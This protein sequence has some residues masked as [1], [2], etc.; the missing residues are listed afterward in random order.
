M[1]TTLTDQDKTAVVAFDSY[2]EAEK[3]VDYLSDKGFP[4]QHTKI[5]GVG[6][7]L[8][9]HVLGRL[10]YARA[11]G[12]GAATGAWFGLLF[13]IFLAV[14][15]T[16]VVWWLATILWALLWGAVAGASFGLVAH[17]L[18]GGRRDFMSTSQLLADRY[19]VLVDNSHADQARELLTAHRP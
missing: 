2:A 8:V 6:L 1:A 11:A 18:T 17:A 16:G 15:T 12:L 7:R 5:V 4:V 19:E 10:T 9:E 14:F 13:G 3:A